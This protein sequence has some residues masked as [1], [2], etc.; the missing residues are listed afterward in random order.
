MN[1]VPV[2][3]YH[4]KQD[5]GWKEVSR[6]PADWNGWSDIDLSMIDELLTNGLFTVTMGWSMW[7]VVKH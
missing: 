2:I 6:H 1:N 3:A 7:Q 4:S 5:V